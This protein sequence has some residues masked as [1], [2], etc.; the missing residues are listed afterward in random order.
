[1]SV[2]KAWGFILSDHLTSDLLP[3][4]LMV[5]NRGNDMEIKET[6]QEYLR[7]K[8]GW[9]ERFFIEWVEELEVMEKGRVKTVLFVSVGNQVVKCHPV[10][11]KKAINKHIETITIQAAR[12]ALLS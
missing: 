12:S 2:T 7:D 11:W 5:S 6:I 8:Q 4:I 9:D 1:M 10:Q 3:G